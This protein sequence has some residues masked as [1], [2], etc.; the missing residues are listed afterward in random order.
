MLEFLDTSFEFLNQTRALGFLFSGAIIFSLFL[1]IRARAPFWIRFIGVPIVLG[2]TIW[3]YSQLGD[4]LG[5]PYRGA[6][7]EESI[8]LGYDIQP[9]GDELNIVVWVREGGGSRLYLVPW[10]QKKEDQLKEAMEGNKAGKKYL[11]RKP[12]EG[13]T[14]QGEVYRPGDFILYEFEDFLYPEKDPQ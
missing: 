10:S 1:W 8:L 11:I 3:G 6:P 2:L 13:E 9:E 14:Q 12:R 5:Y 7:T 4:I